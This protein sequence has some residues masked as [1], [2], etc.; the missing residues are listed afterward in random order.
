MLERLAAQLDCVRFGVKGLYVF[1]STKNATAG[2]SSDIDLIIH[3]AGTADQQKELELWLEGWSLSLSEVNF[4]KTGCVT[5]GL[6]EVHYVSDEDIARKTSFAVKIGAYTDAAKP[7][8]L[9]K[10]DA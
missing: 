5:K 7:I 4:L 2:P 9:R 10:P 6:L 3:F 1:G 8:L